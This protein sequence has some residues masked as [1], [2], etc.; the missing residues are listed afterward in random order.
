MYTPT[1]VKFSGDAEMSLKMH[2]RSRVQACK[3][4]TRQLFETKL[5]AWRRMY[6][7]RPLESERNFP[8]R[9]ASNLVVPLI[10]IHADTLQA[11]IMAALWKTRPIYPVRLFGRYSDPG[12]VDDIRRAWEDYLQYNAIEPEELD[13]YSVEREWVGEICRY[14]TSTL[15]IPN[16]QRLEDQYVPAGDGTGPNFV[17]TVTYD[18][19]CPQKLAFEDFL[20]PTNY[21]RLED[22]DIKI[23][24]CR[25]TKYELMDRRYRGVYDPAKVDQIIDRPDRTS[26]DFVAMQ[27]ETDAKLKT[28]NLNYQEWDVYECWLNWRAPNQGYNPRIISWY[29]LGTNTLLRSI[30]D[31]YPDQPFVMG[32]LLYRDDSIYGYGLCDT[33]GALQEEV[34]QIHNQRR[35]NMTISNTRVWRV[36]PLSKLHEGYEVYPGAM[37]PAEKD[38]IEP[39]Q[40]GEISQITIDEERLALELA[41]KRSGVSPPMQGSGAGTQGKRGIYTAAGTMS[42]L[43]EGNRRTDL[44]ISDVRYSH[45]RLGRIL[46]RQYALLGLDER[47]LGLFGE[48]TELIQ[49]AANYVANGKLGL[50]VSTSNASVNREIEKQNSMM[51]AQVMDRHY[52]MV[53]NLI[54]GTMSTMAPPQLR[55]YLAKVIK[56]SDKLMEGILRDFDRDDADFLVP[57]PE[58]ANANGAGPAGP[59]AQ[60]N[61]G[62]VQQPGGGGVV[63]ISRGN[64]PAGA[65]TPQDAGGA[66]AV[67]PGT[68]GA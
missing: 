16:M 7:G 44:N 26:P 52:Q 51:L 5:V 32:R 49:K 59:Q 36:N 23:H 34:S 10:G 48:Q 2:L 42:V 47:K 13:L 27:R 1:V 39:L 38:E 8:F 62:M 66:A 24:R 35:D 65:G 56:A 67:V 50:V 18:G 58:I 41:E 43:Q 6:E 19:P 57:K 22:V 20:V 12:K 55:D 3:D 11:R 46:S 21:R 68:G 60:P 9:N 25:L 63:S 37:L 30:Y 17:R 31:Y 4:A 33:L 53:A 40:H 45:L 64:A 15:K 29:H 28:S 61:A 54:Q 14:G